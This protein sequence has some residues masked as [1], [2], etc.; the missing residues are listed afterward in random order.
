MN[1]Y[2]NI[3]ATY[4][5]DNLIFYSKMKH[6]T[7][8]YHFVHDHVTSSSFGISYVSTKDQLAS[9]F[10]KPLARQSFLSLRSKIDISDGS[11]ILQGHIENNESSTSTTLLKII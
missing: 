4:L 6:I 10:T 5:S 8:N 3:G 11:T 7:N 9:V 1:Y 2:D